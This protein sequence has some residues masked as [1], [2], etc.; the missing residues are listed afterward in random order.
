MDETEVITHGGTDRGYKVCRCAA[1]GYTAKCT[2]SND[3]YTIGEDDSGLLY[4]ESCLYSEARR[5]KEVK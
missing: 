5:R 3:F 4:C 2:V 1:C